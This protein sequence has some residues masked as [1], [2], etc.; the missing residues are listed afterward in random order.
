LARSCEPWRAVDAKAKKET[1]AERRAK[2]KAAAETFGKR[3]YRWKT[4]WLQGLLAER[5]PKAGDATILKLLL[6]FAVAAGHNRDE[7]LEQGI[8]THGVKLKSA[9]SWMSPE[10]WPSLKS[11][12]AGQLWKIARSAIMAWVQDP[13]EGWHCHITPEQIEDLAK[14]LGIE[15]KKE[16]KLTREFLELHTK[17]ELV[18]LAEEWGFDAPP[19]SSKR[20]EVIELILGMPAPKCPKEIL[21]LK[22]IEL[23]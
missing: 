22:P 1:P 7:G 21:E 3:L 14:E 5:M 15:V 9:R 13:F 10:F 19:E 12:D 11:L 20:S 23:R 8:K 18:A 2:D 4:A 17:G 6:H 16:W